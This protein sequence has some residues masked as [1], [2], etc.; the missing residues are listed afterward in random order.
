MAPRLITVDASLT[1]ESERRAAR[2]EQK[3]LLDAA[4]GGPAL[5]ATCMGW[6][7]TE[8]IE[9]EVAI[10]QCDWRRLA[11]H[12]A[13]FAAECD[14]VEYFSKEPGMACTARLW[15]GMQAQGLAFEGEL[16]LPKLLQQIEAACKRVPAAERTIGLADLVD[17]EPMPPPPAPP[18]PPPLQAPG[19]AAGGAGAGAGAGDTAG[20]QVAHP[21]LPMGTPIEIDAAPVVA[22]ITYADV[23]GLGREARHVARLDSVLGARTLAAHRLQ[24]SFTQAVAAIL[25]A[26]NG[27]N[28]LTN[29]EPDEQAVFVGAAVRAAEMPL[30][31]TTLPTRPLQRRTELCAAIRRGGEVDAAFARE[32]LPSA[33][34]S[35]LL[36]RV[37]GLLAGEA[38]PA[39]LKSLVA[40]ACGTLGLADPSAADA[41]LRALDGA[42]RSHSESIRN[43][44][45]PVDRIERIRAE[46]AARKT[47]MEAAPKTDA[48]AGPLAS[49]SKIQAE[50]LYAVYATPNFQAL[51]AAIDRMEDAEGYLHLALTAS[52]LDNTVG[53]PCG[54]ATKE[55]AKAAEAWHVEAIF[56]QVVWG[57]VESL[58]GRPR[59]TKLAHARD[60]LPALAAK[61]AVAG[62][63]GVDDTGTLR[64]AGLELTELV[65]T[66][67][68]PSWRTLDTVNDL[69]VPIMR[70]F[71][72]VHASGAQFPKELVHRDLHQLQRIRAPLA[73]VLTLCGVVKQTGKGSVRAWLSPVEQI[74][75]LH[76]PGADDEQ[77][78]A[79]ESATQ[80]YVTDSLEQYARAYHLV[81]GRGDASASMEP[82][83]LDGGN[84]LKQLNQTLRS[85]NSH[86]SRKRGAGGEPHEAGIVIPHISYAFEPSARLIGPAG[87]PRGVASPSE[88]SGVT[89]SVAGSAMSGRAG[90]WSPTPSSSGSVTASVAE[91]ASPSPAPIKAGSFAYDGAAATR[92]LRENRAPHLCTHA[93]LCSKIRDPAKREAAEQA[94]C[95]MYGTHGHE[96]GKA[97]HLPKR[98]AAPLAFDPATFRV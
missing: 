37:A 65:R 30:I 55:E 21:V 81:R 29:A 66:L 61:L 53:S 7:A 4:A 42:L 10:A 84:A 73:R 80:A 20:A 12:G 58:I 47:A 62:L 97:L 25:R 52:F 63:P 69:D 1:Q 44:A 86:A 70:A 46:L 79:I 93:L 74:V 19:S 11:T 23:Y 67:A 87:A 31:Y 17:A 2:G 98:G 82:L 5:K 40:T 15:E 27:G 26:A 89:F 13:V 41:S 48:L 54:P 6:L 45:D 18:Q 34:A 92:W 68:M 64:F 22:A 78:A 36:G 76:G 96:F 94:A 59:L 57:K 35:G 77:R 38:A 88:R 39:S 83:A 95:P 56:H 16:P 71:H 32:S 43:G 85:L 14:D 49:H 75:F 8:I 60:K 28:V 24:R 3:V 72:D 91:P 90:A 51:E 50:L 33:I 9:G